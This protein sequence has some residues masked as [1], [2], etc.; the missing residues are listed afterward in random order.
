M[1][2]RAATI[3]VTNCKGRRCEDRV[4]IANDHDRGIVAD[5]IGGCGSGDLA[6]EAATEAFASS[7]PLEDAERSLIRAIAV[8]GDVVEEVSRRQ[9]SGQ[10]GACA[11]AYWQDPLSG[12]IVFT[13]VGDCAVHK[14]DG[15]KWIKLSEGHNMAWRWRKDYGLTDEEVEEWTSSDPGGACCLVHHL[16]C[17]PE[18]GPPVHKIRLGPDDVLLL[19]TDGIHSEL[20]FPP[21]RYV[22]DLNALVKW[23][24]EFA[25]NHGSTDDQACIVLSMGH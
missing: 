15:S 14:Y 18:G 24:S 5:G 20:G 7:P 4:W 10:S 17:M 16:G 3:Q 13:Q 1:M 22:S 9:P 12:L 19:S 23:I 21:S 2:L 6:A 8:A 11:A 25:R